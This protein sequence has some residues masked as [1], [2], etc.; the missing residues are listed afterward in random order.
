M[1]FLMRFANSNIGAAAWQ[2][3]VVLLALLLV[4]V[5]ALTRSAHA[6]DSDPS[7]ILAE[8]GGDLR[9]SKPRLW[10]VTGSITVGPSKRGKRF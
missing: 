6:A 2:N 1:L 3:C 4:Q 7:L 10:S 8:F 5:L 9:E